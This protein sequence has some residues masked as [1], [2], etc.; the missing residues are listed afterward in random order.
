[1]ITPVKRS[2]TCYLFQS[3]G[4]LIF[5]ENQTR[6]PTSH[7]EQH[8]FPMQIKLRRASFLAGSSD[9]SST[10]TSVSFQSRSFS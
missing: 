7:D 4:D 6:Q 2:L 10:A 8:C 5:A 1:M 3:L 9:K